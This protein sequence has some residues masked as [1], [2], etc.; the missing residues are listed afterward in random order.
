MGDTLNKNE[1]LTIIFN[2]SSAEEI[3]AVLESNPQ[4]RDMNF[5]QLKDDKDFQQALKDYKLYSQQ[6]LTDSKTLKSI[7][8]MSSNGNN[9]FTKCENTF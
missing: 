5:I 3:E 2:T 1:D 9:N 6:P 8:K 4:F 7:K